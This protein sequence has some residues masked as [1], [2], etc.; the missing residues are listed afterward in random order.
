[1]PT[2]MRP[3]RC[4]S[5]CCAKQ[6]KVALESRRRQERGGGAPSSP[7]KDD[8]TEEEHATTPH[9]KE[10][11]KKKA[12]KKTTISS[13]RGDELYRCGDFKAAAKAYGEAVAA[14]L[15]EEVD[16]RRAKK[17]RASL[18]ANRAACELMRG[19]A[20]MT[21]S[22][23][24]L[25]AYGRA[26]KD[27]DES[28]RFDAQNAKALLRR[29]AAYLAMGDVERCRRDC[30]GVRENSGRAEDVD[31]VERAKEALE[32]AISELR[33]TCSPTQNDSSLLLRALLRVY[34]IGLAAKKA[35]VVAKHAPLGQLAEAALLYSFG[36]GGGGARDI[37]AA[38]VLLSEAIRGRG[39]GKGGGGYGA[40]PGG[41]PPERAALYAFR[42]RCSLKLA[43][44]AL[45]AFKKMKSR[46]L[47]E[48]AREDVHRSASAV[49]VSE[50]LFASDAEILAEKV[51]VEDAYYLVRLRARCDLLQAVVFSREAPIQDSLL[52][53]VARAT[54]T[55]EAAGCG[56]NCPAPDIDA[57]E[58]AEIDA[59][60][61]RA[62]ALGKENHFTTR[63]EDSSSFNDE[64]PDFFFSSRSSRG[65]DQKTS[66]S[67]SSS[68]SKKKEEADDDE[69]PRASW[70]SLTNEVPYSLSKNTWAT[71]D[72]AYADFEKR[73]LPSAL[74]GSLAF[75]ALPLPPEFGSV[76][77]P[78]ANA[79]ERKKALR[80]ALLRWHPDK[81]SSFATKFN[82]QDRHKVIATAAAIT[83]R[84]ILEKKQT[85]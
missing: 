57:S 34:D 68:S 78:A 1:M 44:I 11:S 54:A 18:L 15:A 24:A 84:I 30:L 82:P 42:A 75:S 16:D 8:G 49:G 60:I 35:K 61:S 65:A 26:L 74:E 53:S 14:S 13:S 20:V 10:S 4:F 51:A 46:K 27:C 79:D 56:L 33:S 48:E 41:V 70:H 66:S 40:P 43:G 81:A 36:G 69:T 28:L 6:A 71:Y 50:K 72:K 31:R 32:A 85:S 63:E 19:H 80:A 64:E 12:K 25:E 3:R 17:K 73:Q 52:V 55:L 7:E 62:D 47:V 59:D 23:L 22:S 38:R 2:T 77:A 21:D 58:Q 76:A 39:I 45:D 29:A 37:E 5:L 9:K 67:S 83:R